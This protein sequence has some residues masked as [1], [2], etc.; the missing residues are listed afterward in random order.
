M[1]AAARSDCPRARS[2][3]SQRVT[4]RSF[5]L[6]LV[7]TDFH[8]VPSHNGQTS[9]AFTGDAPSGLELS[10]FEPIIFKPILLFRLCTRQRLSR[11]PESLPSCVHPVKESHA[12]WRTPETLS[13]TLQK[14]PG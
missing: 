10:I 1:R 9:V 8:P 3:Q 2:R 13:A 5:G 4:R 7:P 6:P 11:K 14:P 12:L